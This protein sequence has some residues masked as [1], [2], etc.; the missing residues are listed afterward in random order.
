M[1]CILLHFTSYHIISCIVHCTV[2]TMLSI[3]LILCEFNFDCVTICF[4]NVSKGSKPGA[5]VGAKVG[6]KGAAATVAED[7]KHI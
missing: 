2:T 6:A 3:Y 5:K 4:I 1:F 7:G